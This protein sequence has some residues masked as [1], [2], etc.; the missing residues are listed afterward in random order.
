MVYLLGLATLR[1]ETLIKRYFQTVMY[2]RYE[3][4]IVHCHWYEFLYLRNIQ[5]LH[6]RFYVEYNLTY[7]Q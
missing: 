6:T 2:I 3:Q 7:H 5:T 1:A 4:I